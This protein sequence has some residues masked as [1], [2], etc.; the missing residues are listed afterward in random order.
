MSDNAQMARVVTNF[1]I[2]PNF[3]GKVNTAVVDKKGKN[4]IYWGKVLTEGEYPMKRASGIILP[5]SSLPSAYGIGTFGKAAYRFAD[6]LHEAGQKYWQMLPLGPTSFG[7]SP[8]Q[9]FSTF[10][11]NPYFIDPELLMED[12]LLTRQEAE[13]CQWG[14]EPRYVDYGKQYESRYVILQ[15]AK[16]R[17]WERDSAEVAAFAAEDER[18][19][20]EYAL[21]MACKRHFGM[22]SWLEWPDEKLR[23]RDAETL[24]KYREM[25]RED[26]EFFTYVQ[27]LF[28]KQWEKLRAYVHD[29]G[30]EIIGD[31]PIYVAMDSADVWSEPEFF[32]LDEKGY[33]TDVSGV[34]PDYFTADGQLWGN[35]L[36]DWD[37]MKRDGY[38]WWI[39]RIDGAGK[40]YDAIRIDHF[41]GLDEYWAVPYGEETARNGE[42]RKGPG[43]ELI[44]VLS[45]WF[46]QIRFIAEDLGILSP[47]VE[48]LLA[49]SGWPGMK[50]LQFA[51]DGDAANSYLPHNYGSSRCICYTGTHDNATLLGWR[52]EEQAET[53]SFAEEYLGLNEDEGFVWGMIRGGMSSVAELFM[54]TMQDYLELGKYHRMNTPGVAVGNWQWRLLPG[55][56]DEKLAARIRCMTERYGR[57]ENKRENEKAEQV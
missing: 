1:A 17:G 2:L 23:L 13:A 25:L 22:K 50:V 47:G 28:Y 33:P 4:V 43:M 54:T 53:V 27:F 49:E 40:L 16:E 52:E 15:K 30:I 46:P 11:G 31:V 20:R 36:Y 18:W 26:V 12:G 55:E 5:I 29:L 44:R 9:S 42:W 37:A 21:F 45:G 57:C 14:T 32:Q 34:P 6:F 7:D 19:L 8:Y 24:E 39:R 51:F 41:R 3:R 38:G 10:A 35:P 56:A 48:E